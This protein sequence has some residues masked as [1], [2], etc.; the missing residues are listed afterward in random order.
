MDFQNR[1]KLVNQPHVQ[2]LSEF[3]DQLLK[4]LPSGSFVPNFDP[5]DGGIAARV[6]LLLETPG[7]VPRSTKFTSLDNPSSTSKNLLPMVVSAGL[8]R[9]DVLMWN[10]VHWDIGTKTKVQPTTGDH[11]SIGTPALLGLLRLL[12]RLRAIVFFGT[13]AQAAMEDV[14][15]V[16]MHLHLLKSP[17]PS[18]TNLNTRPESRH[19][20]AAALTVAAEA[21]SDG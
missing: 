15:K 20:I 12:T 21:L 13:K 14:S 7:R 2:P 10:L 3:R 9:S 4:T 17:H 5:L 18:P 16:H 19:K 8:K 11:H 6:L 1:L